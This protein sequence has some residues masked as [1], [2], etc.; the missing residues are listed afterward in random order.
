MRKEQ[1]C[2]IAG[3]VYVLRR[4]VVA[5][6]SGAADAAAATVA[7][8]AHLGAADAAAATAA[9]AA[10]PLA[11]VNAV[12]AADPAAADANAAVL[13]GLRPVVGDVAGFVAAVVAA[14]HAH[15]LDL[16]NTLLD[17][18]RGDGPGG[19]GERGGGRAPQY[20]MDHVCVRCASADEYRHVCAQL[21]A[22]VRAMGVVWECEGMRVF[23]VT[24]P[25]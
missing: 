17:T 16:D 8:A 4:P 15:G 11:V 22:L 10:A 18:P 6:H 24:L 25:A 21:E 12:A 14:L 20:E 13:A 19:G 5:E 7:A 9:A 3:T 23:K 1:G 2:P